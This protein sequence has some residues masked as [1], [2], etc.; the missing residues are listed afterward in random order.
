MDYPDRRCAIGWADVATAMKMPAAAI[1]LIIVLHP[2][3]GVDGTRELV[4]EAPIDT[5][6]NSSISLMPASWV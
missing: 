4:S 1:I 2:F 3:V 6:L 5:P